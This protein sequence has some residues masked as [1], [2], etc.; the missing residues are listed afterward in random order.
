MAEEDDVT[1][2]TNA[3]TIVITEEGS[4]RAYVFH[5]WQE[6]SLE[7]QYE[8]S[9]KPTSSGNTTDIARRLPDTMRLNIRASDDLEVPTTGGPAGIYQSELKKEEQVAAIRAMNGKIV[10]VDSLRVGSIRG[11]LR[12]VKRGDVIEVDNALS[13]EVEIREVVE[14][15]ATL[16]T[17]LVIPFGAVDPGA[18]E[19]GDIDADTEAEMPASPPGSGGITTQQSS[20][21]V[22]AG[23]DFVLLGV[24]DLGGAVGSIGQSARD[25]YFSAEDLVLQGWLL[26][27]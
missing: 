5:L 25:I 4:G 17:I 9:D 15:G 1:P 13:I 16:G 3:P 2:I 22:V 21:T 6:A 11:I 10:T 7:S 19:V 12:M 18:D 26:P 20:T 27:F 8:V 14:V 24:I 23:S